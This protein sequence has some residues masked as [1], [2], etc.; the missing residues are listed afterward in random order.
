[1]D[2]FRTSHEVN[3]LTLLSDD[4]IR[5]MIDDDLVRAHRDRALEPGAS[6]GA[7]HRAQSR[8]VLP[9]ARDG[10]PLLRGDLP[11]IVQASDG[12]LAALCGRS[13]R[14]FRYDGHPRSGA[15]HRRD[16]VRRRGGARDGAWL[17]ARG[18]KVGALQVLLYRPFS[19]GAL[20]RRAA[21]QRARRSRCSTAA[22]N[23]AGWASRSTRTWSPRSPRAVAERQAGGHAARDRRPLRP[24]VEGIPS[25]HGQG[26]VRRARKPQPQGRLHHRHQ[27][28]RLRHQPRL[29]PRSRHRDPRRRRARCSTGSAPTARSAPTRTA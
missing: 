18:E 17:P 14:L 13:Y 11:G 21:G 24:V 16:G 23:P 2:G 10:E 19:V 25:G 4:A 5:A 27:R 12:R 3:S 26:G 15:R 28:R 29:R 8:H 6:R 20:P 7:R 9:G 22:R 1:M